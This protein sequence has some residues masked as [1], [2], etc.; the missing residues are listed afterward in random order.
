ML[1]RFICVVHGLYVGVYMFY[2]GMNRLYIGFALVLW[3]N[4]SFSF[5]GLFM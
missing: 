5:V 2:I 4:I 1:Y 3:I